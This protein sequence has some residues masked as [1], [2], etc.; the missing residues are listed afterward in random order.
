[1]WK[2]LDGGFELRVRHMV[3]VMRKHESTGSL[4]LM[5]ML[6]CMMATALDLCSAQVVTL[7][8]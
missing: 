2:A 8:S 1:M 3:A 5:C 4:K 7:T 6:I